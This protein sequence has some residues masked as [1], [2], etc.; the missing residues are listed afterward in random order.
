MDPLQKRPGGG[1]D[2]DMSSP[3]PGTETL[4]MFGRLSHGKGF[5]YQNQEGQAFPGQEHLGNI[6]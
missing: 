6:N 3:A 5:V 2:D 1:R 4:D